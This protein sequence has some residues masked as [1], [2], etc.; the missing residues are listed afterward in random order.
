[1]YGHF[2]S[3]PMAVQECEKDQ[4]TW[5]T[6]MYQKLYPC[7]SCL[8][9]VPS[10]GRFFQPLQVI[11][12]PNAAELFLDQVM[13]TSVTIS[14]YLKKIIPI[15]KLTQQQRSEFHGADDCHICWKRFTGNSLLSIFSGLKQFIPKI[16]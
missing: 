8:Y 4:T 6:Q 14:Q 2:E 5:Y 13:A 11:H 10:D 7:G 1:M 12:G 9:I 3:V 15:G 16:V